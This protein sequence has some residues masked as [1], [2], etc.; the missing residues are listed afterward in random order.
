MRG[1]IVTELGNGFYVVVNPHASN[2]GDSVQVLNRLQHDILQKQLKGVIDFNSLSENETIAFANL[3]KRGVFDEKS[4]VNNKYPKTLSIWL[5][6]T[7]QCN[8]ACTY[9]HVVKRDQH[10][11]D[12]ML[13]DF[14]DMLVKTT[15][16]KGLREITL[17]L[18]G[19][20]PVLRFSSIHD[21]IEDTRNR[22][23]SLNCSLKIAMLS[24]L[25]SLPTQVV[26]FVKM[27]K[28]G[29][30]VSMD[31]IGEVQDK[32]R[33]LVNGEGSFI[34]VRKNIEK[35]QINGV[36]P[37]ILTVIS[38]ENVEGLVDFT[39][40]LISENLGFRYSFQKGGELNRLR[41]T[42]VLRECYGLIE[43]A[44]LSGEYT[45][46]HRHRLADLSIFN[47]QKTACG[48]GRNTCSVYLDGSIYMCQMQHGNIKPLG[49][50]TEAR[51]LC[52]I[53]VDRTEQND[54]HGLD[55]TCKSCN[56]RANCAGGCPI[57]RQLV[58]GHN[59][60]CSLFKEFLPR[61]HKIHGLKKLKKIIGD[62]KFTQKFYSFNAVD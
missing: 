9:C 52:E 17:R 32:S 15:K 24:G 21:W 50:V 36:N 60:N 37:Y 42:Q 7:D 4:V 23:A 58:G 40:W 2:P 48:A 26:E 18:A 44:V 47:A 33:P 51:D 11:H 3:E 12:A 29:I 5:H 61:I 31:G 35:L 55:D 53:L 39:K 25:A 45:Q 10:M 14:A 28:N 6:V 59:P 16:S 22:L 30:S 34:K 13:K 46:F 49:N 19:G 62:E 41:V 27:P 38:D 8:M 57:D 43:S 20:E 1:R 56:L 54:F